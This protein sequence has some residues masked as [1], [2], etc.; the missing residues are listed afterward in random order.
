[1]TGRSRRAEAVTGL[2]LILPALLWVGLLVAYPFAMAIY[3]SLSNT[4]V[5]QGGHFV[6]LAN[7]RQLVADES[8]RQTLQNSIVFTAVAV[9]VKAVLGVTLALILYR[10][11]RFKRLVRG[12]VL[13]PFVIPTAL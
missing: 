2:T 8:F 12:L 6:G 13:L 3:Y 7:F 5:G 9:A 1:V 11:L 10:K 4:V